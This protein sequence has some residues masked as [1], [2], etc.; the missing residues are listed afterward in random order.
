MLGA[1]VVF[2][3][4]TMVAALA[5]QLIRPKT[6]R[7]KALLRGCDVICDVISAADARQRKVGG[8]VRQN[9]ARVVA[10][11]AD[12]AGAVGTEELGIDDG[13]GAALWRGRHGGLM[14]RPGAVALFAVD[15][16]VRRIA[17]SGEIEDAVRVVHSLR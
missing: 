6:R 14:V 7:R 1:Q 8:F 11:A 3:R 10:A 16:H 4:Q 2:V 15:A 9:T 12:Q 5:V 17:V 13:L